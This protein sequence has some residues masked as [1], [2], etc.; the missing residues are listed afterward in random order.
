MFDL[1]GEETEDIR[2]DLE[3]RRQAG[4]AGALTEAL[5]EE[6]DRRGETADEWMRPVVD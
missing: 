1:T 4:R 3:S 6:L 2:H 5:A